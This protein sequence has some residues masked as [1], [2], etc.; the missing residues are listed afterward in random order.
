MIRANQER[1]SENNVEAVNLNQ[2]RQI[3]IGSRTGRGQKYE[4]PNVS[5]A[6]VKYSNSS[7]ILT[8]LNSGQLLVVDSRRRNGLIVYKRFHAEFAGPG[9][10]V[11]GLFDIDC[12]QTIPVG[13]LVL[14]YPDSYEER[15]KAFTI[16]RHWIRVMEQLTAIPVPLQ[17]AQ[18]LITQFEHYFDLNTVGRLPDEALGRLVGVMPQTVKIL[19]QSMD[20]NVEMTVRV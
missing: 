18:M 6:L 19:R 4:R 10:A 15:Q 7:E 14:L 2:S 9:A 16:R 1:Y 8:Q 5:R 20:N 13:D 12:Q 17:R 3:E 11:G